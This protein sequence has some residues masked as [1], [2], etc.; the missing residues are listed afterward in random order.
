MA[1]ENAEMSKNDH[2]YRRIRRWKMLE[3]HERRIAKIEEVQAEPV[4]PPSAVNL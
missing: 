4:A 3:D 2:I 1:E